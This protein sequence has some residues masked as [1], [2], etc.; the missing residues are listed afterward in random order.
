MKFASDD[1]DSD[2]DD[3]DDGDDGVDRVVTAI[4]SGVWARPSAQR[5]PSPC[6]KLAHSQP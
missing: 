5:F 2:D 1:D 3:D 6:F 4:I